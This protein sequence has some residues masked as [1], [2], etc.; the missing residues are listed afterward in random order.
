MVTSAFPVSLLDSNCIPALGCNPLLVPARRLQADMIRRA[1][2]GDEDA[3]S[4]LYVQHKKR[5]YGICIR[6]VRDAG[7]AEDLTQ[8]AFLQLYRNLAKFR[9]E[10]AFTTWLHRLTMNVVL[11]HMRKRTLPVISLEQMVENIPK[12]CA[13]RKFSTVDLALAGVVDR[14]VIKSALASLAPGYRTIFILH[15]IQGFEHREIAA[16]ENCSLGNS[17]SQLH[18]ARRSLQRTLLGQ[19]R[20]SAAKSSKPSMRVLAFRSQL[21]V[22]MLAT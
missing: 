20:L 4:E 19:P 16:I 3:F 21:A 22:N 17:K 18:K 13:G 15:D 2:A 10:S 7:L 14:I 12:A 1:I 11:M 8:D 9:G 5:V 6:M